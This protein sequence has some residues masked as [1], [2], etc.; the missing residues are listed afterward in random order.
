MTASKIADDTARFTN[1]QFACGEI[2]RTKT[3]FKETIDT[4]CR[5]IGQIQRG[6]TRAAEVGRIR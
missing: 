6:G 3:N 1:Q 5:N 2:P 4:T